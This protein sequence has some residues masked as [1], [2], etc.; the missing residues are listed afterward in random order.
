MILLREIDPNYDTPAATN[1]V[2]Q[3]IPSVIMLAPLLLTL[4][5]AAKSLTNTFIALGIYVVLFVGYNVFLFRRKIFKKYRAIPEQEWVE[6]AEG[7]EAS[8]A[9]TEDDVG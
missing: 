6:S 3:N 9:S 7:S 4:G 8:V 1:I 2:L 5:F